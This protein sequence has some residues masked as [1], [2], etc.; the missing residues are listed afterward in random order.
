MCQPCPPTGDSSLSHRE[1]G[2]APL[3]INHDCRVRQ[4]RVERIL[5]LTIAINIGYV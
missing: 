1:E 3:G 2:G 5:I 4:K